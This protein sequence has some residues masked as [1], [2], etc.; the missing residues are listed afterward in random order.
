MVNYK[1]ETKMKKIVM[2]AAMVMVMATAIALRAKKDFKYL[3][4]N[5]LG[6]VATKSKLLY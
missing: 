3:G 5:N 4:N 1:E 6:F 2:M